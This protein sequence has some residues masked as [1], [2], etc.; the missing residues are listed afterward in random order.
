M[1]YAR[2]TNQQKQQLRTQHIAHPEMS[3]HQ[4]AEWALVAFKLSVPP[5][6]MTIYR[7]LKAPEDDSLHPSHKSNRSVV[8]PQLDEE[9]L[10]WIRECERWKLPIVTGATI[11]EKADAIRERLIAEAAP[12][13]LE[14]LSALTFSNGWLSRFQKRY[15]LSS[16]IAHGEAASVKIA[17]VEQGRRDLRR[18]TSSYARCDV[19]NMD[20]TA[21]FY[22]TA[23]SRSISAA[24]FSGRKNI[25]KRMTVAVAC[26]ADGSLKLPLLFVGAS[27][28]PRCFRG[29]SASELGVDYSSTA[30]GWMTAELFQH[31]AAS[32]NDRMHAENRH[33]L[34]LLDNVSSH[35]LDASLSNVKV[36]MLPPN[37]TSFLQPQDAGI[38]RQFK[39]KISKLQNR[40]VVERFD[41]LLQRADDLDS[42]TMQQE[43]ELLRQVDVLE[44]MR[45]AQDA[46]EL[47]TKSTVTNC[48]RHTGILD[49]DVYELVEKLDGL[50]LSHSRLNDH[51]N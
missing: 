44:A 23:P 20:E 15:G 49:D 47:V 45:W 9:L 3:Q 37:T 2:L 24:R 29:K 18:I 34:L 51:L 30:K 42:H 21:Y 19:F 8:S 36:H 26:N 6:R 41:A 31:W 28:Q 38:I 17:D 11:C 7:V 14:D 39:L 43:I 32:L 46:W 16:N 35:R 27:R 12:S 1:Q 22:C 5:S 48:W 33:V 50:C 4:L 10:R 25:K 13:P 40:R